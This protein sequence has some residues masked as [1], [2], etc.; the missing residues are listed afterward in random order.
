MCSTS[1]DVQWESGTSSVQAGR[2]ST[3][4]TAGGGGGGWGWGALLKNIFQ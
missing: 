1:K 3:F 2:S 4:G